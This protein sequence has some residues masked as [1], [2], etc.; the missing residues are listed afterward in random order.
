MRRYL[1]SLFGLFVIACALAVP[2]V[3]QVATLTS[4]PAT[5]ATI[6]IPSAAVLTAKTT[7]VALLPAASGYVYVVA[8]AEM[9]VSFKSAAYSS[10][11]C[12]LYY[13]GTS[14]L[15]LAANMNTT[16]DAAATST[17]VFSGLNTG[18]IAGANINGLGVDFACTTADPTTGDSPLKIVI[19]YVQ[20]PL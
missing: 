13:H 11:A 20:V 4:T 5:R 7:P 10:T 16:V 15:A 6:T 18:A 8:W 9:S 19:E 12:G 1:L 2:C 17:G 14:Q 3:A